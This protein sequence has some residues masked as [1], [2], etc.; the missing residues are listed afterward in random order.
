VE[1]LVVMGLMGALATISTSGYYAVVRGMEERGALSAATGVIRAAQQ[2]ARIDRVPTAIYFYNELVEAESSDEFAK[3]QGVAVA[4]RMGGR[5]SW[6][7]GARLYDE[8]ADLGAIYGVPDPENPRDDSQIS[9]VS[10]M[11]LYK[12]ANLNANKLDYT[13]VGSQVVLGGSQEQHFIGWAQSDR[14]R[15]LPMYAFVKHKD[16]DGNAQWKTGD[17]Y[18]LEFA[19]VR[20]PVGYVFGNQ[21]PTTVGE[22]IK[23][24]KTVTFDPEKTGETLEFTVDV[25]SVRPG[26]GGTPELQKVGTTKT[27]A[28][29]I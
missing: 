13:L 5:I 12:M 2:R 19:T 7:S 26:K 17:A 21:Y 3:A 22:P 15:E 8:F 18:A 14:E 29:S 28:T 25:Y 20:L 27:D 10:G 6:V 1:L 16:D 23:S 24:I 11:R 4:V 9:T